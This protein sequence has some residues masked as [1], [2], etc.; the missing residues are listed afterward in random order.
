MER[1]L[2]PNCRNV[3]AR[4]DAWK[5]LDSLRR[6]GWTGLAVAWGLE[7][8]QQPSP[9]KFARHKGRFTWTDTLHDISGTKADQADV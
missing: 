8:G 6:V 5:R 3:R 4:V 2:R 7:T 9:Q 1:A